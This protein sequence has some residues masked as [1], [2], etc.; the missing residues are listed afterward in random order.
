MNQSRLEDNQNITETV[1]TEF[2]A[3]LKSK[4]TTIQDLQEK[5][6]VAN[7]YIRIV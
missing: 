7:Q 1:R 6:T 3:L 4:D 5:L 2:D